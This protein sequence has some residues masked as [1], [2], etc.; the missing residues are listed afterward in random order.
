M[1]QKRLSNETRFST[2]VEETNHT[3]QGVFI[4]T[5]K[6]Q[7]QKSLE[8]QVQIA[9]SDLELSKDEELEAIAGGE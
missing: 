8:Q 6:M 5:S 9:S 7:D 2:I 4:M 3:E 1:T